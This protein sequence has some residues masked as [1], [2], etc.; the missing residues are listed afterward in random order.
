MNF[1]NIL[2]NINSF[3][4]NLASPIVVGL[5]LLNNKPWNQGVSGFNNSTPSVEPK[6]VL[7]KT[8]APTINPTSTPTPTPTPSTL[9][10]IM[11]VQKA[12]PNIT[13]NIT[14]PYS[15]GGEKTL[16][17]GLSQILLN[18]FN[19]IGQATNSAKVL[20]HPADN[21]YLPG[22]PNSVNK[23]TYGENGS[24]ITDPNNPRFNTTNSDGSTDRG[25]FRINSNSYNGIMADPH[26]GQVAR[27]K[28]GI[29]SYD[30]MNDPQKN[31]YMAKIIYERNSGWRGWFAAPRDLRAQGA[32][33]L[34]ALDEMLANK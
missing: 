33:D 26:W 32:P 4:N 30:D 3:A 6:T 7:A 10:D 19:D 13:P 34:A 22:D 23:I 21:P 1:G 9:N 24:F 18:A 8:I 31:A 17:P 28:F 20:N 25:L 14:I 11:S 5:N 2:S 12:N 29:N 15:Q 16:D 27:Q